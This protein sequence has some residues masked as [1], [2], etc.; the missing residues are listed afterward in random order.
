MTTSHAWPPGLDSGKSAEPFG[1]ILE[2]AE[3][4]CACAALVG[5]NFMVTVTGVLLIICKDLPGV[6]QPATEQATVSPNAVTQ[7]AIRGRSMA[8]NVSTAGDPARPARSQRN[9]RSM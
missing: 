7:A 2:T 4:C 5:Q 9:R 1:A 8:G 3:H 6:P